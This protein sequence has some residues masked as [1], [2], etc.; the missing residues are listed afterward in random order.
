VQ[1]LLNDEDIVTLNELPL[2][3]WSALDFN[4]DGAIDSADYVVWR[5]SNGQ[6]G[7]NLKADANLDG[8]VNNTD[9]VLWRANYGRIAISAGSG[10][11][12]SPAVPEPSGYLLL[13]V[14]GAFGAVRGRRTRCGA[15]SVALLN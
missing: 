10:A 8:I 13:L 11:L 5:K 7:S 4:R 6:S 9:Y 14:G 2:M 12:G 1:T 15:P 3:P